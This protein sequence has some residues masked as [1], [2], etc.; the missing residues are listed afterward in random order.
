MCGARRLLLIE[1]YSLA[2]TGRRV[3]EG[4]QKSPSPEESRRLKSLGRSFSP[5]TA[6]TPGRTYDS[7]SVAPKA[8]KK[9]GRSPSSSLALRSVD[10]RRTPAENVW[11]PASTTDRQ[12]NCLLLTQDAGFLEG[13]KKPERSE[14]S[15]PPLCSDPSFGKRFTNHLRGASLCARR[16]LALDATPRELRQAEWRC[17]WCLTTRPVRALIGAALLSTRRAGSCGACAPIHTVFLL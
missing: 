2:Y 8:S 10:A 14:A 17:C 11:H 16:P 9:K 15:R 1:T 5:L 13:S 12:D 4:K 6:N 7:A 3:P